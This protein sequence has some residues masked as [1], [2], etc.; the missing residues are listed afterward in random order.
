MDR[1]FDLQL[2]ADGGDGSSGD[3]AGTNNGGESGKPDGDKK[4]TADNPATDNGEDAAAKEAELQKKIE[5]AVAK[6][7]KKW[8]TEYQKRL[9]DE[10]KKA[11]ALSKLSDDERRKAEL[12]AKE[13]ELLAQKQE[14]A[15]KE[16]ALE[17]TKVLAER[18]IPV[19][20]M[21]FLLAEDS[22]KTMERIKLFEKYRKKD[23][24]DQVNERL[25]GRTPTAGASND[26][27][28]GNANNAGVKN[29]FFEAI[30]KNQSKR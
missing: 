15:R 19:E 7:Q 14:L 4:T 2:F 10:K 1:P 23:I 21:D 28:G 5:D 18:K 6:A 29:G 26:P 8:E 25:K 24:E 11:E 9:D 3:S 30:T 12:E 22:E 20:F 16:L 13:Q 27:K 17:M